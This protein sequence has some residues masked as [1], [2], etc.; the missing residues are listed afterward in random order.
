MQLP[1]IYQT[2]QVLLCNPCRFLRL[3]GKRIFA[4][5]SRPPQLLGCIYQLQL[6]ARSLT[7]PGLFCGQAT[8]IWVK[9]RSAHYETFAMNL[10][11]S[12]E[13][14][15]LRTT[16]PPM[17]YLNRQVVLSDPYRFSAMHG[18]E[19]LASIFRQPPASAQA[20]PLVQG[21]AVGARRSALPSPR[22]AGNSRKSG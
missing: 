20:L 3:R 11:H 8:A 5:V 1:I 19:T 2:R 7:R 4:F 17:I 13:H 6:V 12:A 16:Q 22:L 14:L 15:R 10:A 21:A 9:R 18:N